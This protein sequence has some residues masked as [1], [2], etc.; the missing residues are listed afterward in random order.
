MKPST[1]CASISGT[2]APIESSSRTRCVAVELARC[3][4]TRSVPEPGSIARTEP[5][6]FR[7][8][9]SP[10]ARSD[11]Y[12]RSNSVRR[13][14]S[15]RHLRPGEAEACAG[16]AAP[17]GPRRCVRTRIRTATAAMAAEEFWLTRCR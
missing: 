6:S 7:A 14:Q 11:P 1:G 12:T 2:E 9:A 15:R 10:P 4:S 13:D 17:R 8:H 16:R 3:C 5:I